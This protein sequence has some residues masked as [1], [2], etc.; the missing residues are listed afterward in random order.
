MSEVPLKEVLGLRGQVPGFMGQGLRVLV[1]VLGFRVY[2]PTFM[3]LGLWS[4][5]L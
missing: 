2:R 5:G 1:D 3:G 4:Q